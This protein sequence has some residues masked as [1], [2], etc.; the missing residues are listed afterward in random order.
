MNL[1]QLSINRPVTVT[2]L[3]G[4]LVVFGLISLSRVGVA[5]NPDVDF[6]M[7]SVR[8]LWPGAGP[9]EVDNEITDAL[10]DAVSSINGIKHISSS[11]SQNVSYIMVEFELDTDL[12]VA[13]Q[14]VR[15]KISGALYKIPA[16][17]EPPVVSKMDINAQPIMWISISGQ[18]ALE[19]LTKI[20][21][22]QVRVMF[23]KIDGVG[24]IVIPGAREKEVKIWLNRERLAAY[25]VGVDEVISSIRSQHIEIPG[26]K[27]EST[28][29]EFLIRTMGELETAEAFTDLIVT[30]RSG[31]PIRLGMLGYAESGREDT[32]GY[33]KIS[34]R[35]GSEKTIGLG[36]S[37]RSG[38]NHVA[39]AER[40][41]AEIPNIEKILPEGMTIKIVMDNTRF[42]VQSINEVKFQLILGAIMAALVIFFFLQNIRT[43]LI[44]SV[45]IPTSIISTFACIYAMGFTLNNLTMLALITAV[46]LVVDDAIV[47]VENIFRHREA[48]GKGSMAAA[49]DGSSEVTF[50]V[51]ASTTALLGVF[52][53]VAFMQ[54][55]V[56]KFFYHFAVTMAFAVVCST[57][58][59]MTIIPMLS[60]R[61][62]RM[63]LLGDKS[64]FHI[65]NRMMNRLSSGYKN[66]LR[67]SLAHR[68]VIIGV[69]ILSIVVA[70]VLFSRVGK[71]FTTAED[72]SGSV[73]SFELPLAYSID[74]TNDVMNRVVEMLQTLPE[75]ESMFSIAGMGGSNKGLVMMNLVPVDQRD[76]SQKEIQMALRKMLTV[77]PDAKVAVYDRS[78]MGGGGRNADINLI[79]QGPEVAGIDR[80]S[81]EIIAKMSAIPGFTG[82]TRDLEIGK[83]EVRVIIDRERAADAGVS[84]SSIGTA[85]RA[86]LG[87]VDVTTFKEGGKTYDI[88]LRLIPGQRLLP[89]DVERIWIRTNKGELTDISN[90]TKLEI[91]VGPNTINRRD[92]QRSAT[93]Y[94]NLEGL[95]LGDAMPM[96]RKIADETLPEGY[97]A[98]FSGRSEVFGETVGYIV[99]AFLLAVLL[100]YMVL[101][102]QFESFIQ[103][104]AIMMGLPLAFVGAFGLLYILGN[105]LNMYSMIGLVLLIGLVTKNG[106]LLIDYANQQREKGMDMKGALVEAGATRLRPILMTAVS[107]IAGVLPVAMG[108]GVGSESRQPLA[109]VI[110]GGM[111][112]STVLTLAVVPVI[113]SYLDQFVN[114]GIFHK[115]KKQLM[116]RDAHIKSIQRFTEEK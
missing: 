35:K 6:P 89:E 19:Y 37:P 72:T 62:L 80:Y 63:Q 109:V 66:M 22:E 9:E 61:F 103:P 110:C 4:A 8:T 69:A 115:M 108:L 99:F 46:G 114:L 25:K 102:G 15:D 18:H 43:T 116:A 53:P 73:V 79:L 83:P 45:A 90:F 42:I 81:K 59:A 112:S 20:A 11:S 93:I 68:W 52:I 23:Q 1:P 113:Y 56:G 98:G 39:I 111:I 47:M 88:R 55:M 30:Y 65:F 28:N 36:I 107:T 82:V 91:G 71:E 17:A 101:A 40:V 92:R 100:T 21:N 32:T 10:E 104:F 105:T 76:R 75:L 24:G 97:T 2:M 84:I 77:L 38:A 70:M 34:D 5:L 27:I 95:L 67:W 16:D 7:I 87:G 54:G 51:L 49:I 3:I 74:K 41:R 29:K 85:V 12:E 64:A 50:P 13:S 14:E 31:V 48:L 60:S 86:L 94:T 26:G 57:L 58:V 78:V 44:S 106:I 96:V 33:A